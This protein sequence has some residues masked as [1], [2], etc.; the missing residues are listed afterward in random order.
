M[1]E[2]FSILFGTDD[3]GIIPLHYFVE[4]RKFCATPDAPDFIERVDQSALNR[5]SVLILETVLKLLADFDD[6]EI[7][8]MALRR[9]KILMQTFVNMSNKS[10]R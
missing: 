5:F 3:L 1:T 8:E 9:S 7:H 4:F 2:S 6:Y 10:A